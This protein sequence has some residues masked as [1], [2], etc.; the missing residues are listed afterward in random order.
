MPLESFDNPRHFCACASLFISHLQKY[1]STNVRALPSLATPTS[2]VVTTHIHSR[3]LPVIY[4]NTT[5]IVTSLGQN[6]M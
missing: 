6:P 1:R 2:V 3:P 5:T 4:F